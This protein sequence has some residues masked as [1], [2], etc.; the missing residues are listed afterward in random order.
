MNKSWTASLKRQAV[1]NMLLLEDDHYFGQWTRCVLESQCHELRVAVAKNLTAARELFARYDKR[2]W[3]LVIIDLNLGEESGTDLIGEI[4]Q[5]MPEL[6]MLVV[7]AVDTPEK[8]LAAIRAGAQG[9]V[10]KTT[11]ERELVRVVNQVLDGGSPIT[12]SIARQLLS[13]FRSID[14]LPP[15]VSVAS[16]SQLD[17]PADV[18][19]EKI[20]QDL[21]VREVE[22]L[23]LLARGYSNKESAAELDI[24]PST[25]DTHIRKI[26]RKLSINS[27]VEL[28]RLLA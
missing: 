13:K 2:V 9:Y 25:I 8:A 21:S 17:R 19:P 4:A 14:M 18:L 3:R 1:P 27:R 26:F 6:P 12:P 10:L 28:R 20:L 22:V 7:T 5:S 16:A 15:A 11:I 23:R 24:S